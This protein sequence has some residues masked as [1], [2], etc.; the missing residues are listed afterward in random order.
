MNTRTHIVTFSILLMSLSGCAALQAG[1]EVQ[2]GRRAFLAGDN[3]TAVAYFQRASELDPDYVYDGT[4]VRENIWSYLGR[5]AY[6]AG[7]LAQARQTLEK[8]ITPNR[9]ETARSTGEEQDMARLYLG[10]T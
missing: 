7:R 6:A 10:L 3:E 4:A 8:A 9:D 5:S 1:G 2:A